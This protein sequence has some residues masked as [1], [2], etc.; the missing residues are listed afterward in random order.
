MGFSTLLTAAGL[1]GLSLAAPPSYRPKNTTYYNPIIP[2]FHPDPSCIFVKEWDNTFFCASSSFIAFPAMPIHASKDLVNWKLVSHVQNRPE[3]FP[4]AGNITRASGG[5]YAPTLRYHNSTFWVINADVDAPTTGTG[6]FTSKNPYDNNAWSDLTVVEVGGYDPDLFFDQ[7]E[8]IYSQA[9]VTILGDPFTTD[10]EQFNIDWP[11]GNSTPRHFLSNGTGVQPPE[12]PHI[13]FKDDY[14]WLLLAEGGTA[15][16]HQVTMS[17][18]KHPTGPWELDPANPILTAIN[19][20]SLFQT[21]G[22]ADLFEDAAGN[23]WGVALSTRSGPEYVNWPMNRETVLYP[24]S[25]PKGQWPV[26]DPVRGKMSGPLPPKN[27]KVP[28]TGAFVKDPDYYTFPPGSS[29]PRH[30]TFW[31]FPHTQ[32]YAISPRGHPNRL[33]LTPSN[34]NLTSFPTFDPLAGQTFVARRQVDTLFTYTINMEFSPSK[35]GEEAGV[36]AFLSQDLH[37]DLGV[38]YTNGAP[39][40]RFRAEGPGAPATVVKPMPKSWCET[41]VSFEIE[42]FNFTHYSLSAGAKGTVLETFALVNNSLFSTSF[43][44]AFVGVYATTNGHGEGG[45]PAYFSKW[46]YQGQGQAI[47]DGQ[48][49][50]SNGQRGGGLYSRDG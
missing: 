28:G 44:G 45:S 3:Q 37:A 35:Q 10:I 32:N 2:G 5:W 21:V 31:R 13:Y 14:Y 50:P 41:G 29:L 30:F 26:A 16:D 7:D 20:T 18:S 25:W 19:T 48:Y 6:I 49:Y 9:A 4:G 34:A 46:R 33:R 27:L 38:V 12:G 15:L 17:R 22:H 39:Y 11:S 47:D 43:T 23:W 42:A 8:T 24:V 36:S 40:L 1:A